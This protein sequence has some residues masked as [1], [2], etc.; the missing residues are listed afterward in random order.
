MRRHVANCS[1]QFLHTD[2]AGLSDTLVKGHDLGLAVCQYIRKMSVV[3]FVSVS[4]RVH[5]GEDVEGFRQD[6]LTERSY[7]RS[8]AK[9]SNR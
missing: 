8:L 5:L 3:L 7:L 6:H 1:D 4:R 2:P 9:S